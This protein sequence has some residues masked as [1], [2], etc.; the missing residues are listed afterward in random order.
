MLDHRFDLLLQGGDLN[1]LETALQS[2]SPN[3]DVVEQGLNKCTAGLDLPE[4]DE[5]R[6]D[7]IRKA[8]EEQESQDEKVFKQAIEDGG[9]DLRATALGKRWG[10]EKKGNKMLAQQYAAVGTSHAAQQ[11]FR[12]DWISQKLE[13]IQ[14]LKVHTKKQVPTL[15]HGTTQRSRRAG[16]TS[17]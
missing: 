17:H 14:K 1:A 9:F 8:T 3:G 7:G 10:A 12:L 15:S 11:A 13:Q 16:V 5:I 2:A 4:T 6:P